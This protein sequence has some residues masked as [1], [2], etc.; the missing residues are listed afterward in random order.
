MGKLRLFGEL[1]AKLVAARNAINILPRESFETVLR[2]L[3]NQGALPRQVGELFH[4]LRRAGNAAVHDNLGNAGGGAQRA[5]AS[6]AARYLVYPQLRQGKTIRSWP[7]PTT[8]TAARRY[9]RVGR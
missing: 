7:V 5:E 9:A 8:R 3:R 4:F 1:L 2:E 6:A